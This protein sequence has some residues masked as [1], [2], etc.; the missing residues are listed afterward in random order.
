MVVRNNCFSE[1][2]DYGARYNTTHGAVGSGRG[3]GLSGVGSGPGGHGA[4]NGKIPRPAS[5]PQARTSRHAAN[6]AS[7][8]SMVADSQAI[9]PAPEE[10]RASEVV[11][12]A[13]AGNNAR[14]AEALPAAPKKQA[15]SSEQGARRRAPPQELSI[16]PASPHRDTYHDWGTRLY[17]SNDDT[18]SLSSAQ[19]VI[20][21]IDRG[22]DIPPEHIRPHEFLNY[23][24]FDTAPVHPEDDFSVHASIAPKPDANG[25]YTLGLAVSGRDVTKE[26]RRN[27]GLTMVVD[28]SGSMAEDGRMD[29]LK[30]GLRRMTSELKTGDLVN[31]VLFDH[32]VCTPLENFVV[33]RDSMSV[34]ADTIARIQPNGST[35]LNAGLVR[36]YQLANQSYNEAYTNRVVLI[37]DAIANTGVTDPSLMAT[38]TQNYDQ[39]RIRLSGVG[40]GRDFNDGLLDK[41]TEKGKGA[42]V[43]L[44]SEGEVDAVFGSRFV[45]LIET[46]ANDVHFQLELP[47]SLRMNVFYGEESSVVK[48]DVQAIH[49]FAGTSQLFLSDLMARDGVLTSNERIK[50]NVEYEN[51][52]TG[53]KQTEHFVFPISAIRA[54]SH[55]VSKG[56]LITSFIDGVKDIELSLPR[57]DGV[58][59]ASRQCAAGKQSL[60]E[61][62]QTL[63]TDREVERVL[64]LWE[65]YCK[66]YPQVAYHAAVRPSHDGRYPVR[67]EAPRGKDVW[68]GAQ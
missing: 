19:R 57:Y 30:Q 48:S 64:N 53:A 58:L 6:A 52:E 1:N 3:I 45:S 56:R 60:N 15:A 55:N 27:A 24:S 44:G 39:R 43:F 20:Y 31:I 35:N 34:L 38:V 65:A 7:P 36:G 16:K 9:A 25:V 50:L 2:L 33:G 41:L 5:K 62:A 29:Y 46:I 28:R 42:Y 8:E 18:M 49:Y 54:P 47:P 61:Q 4:P 21:A 22:M 32:Q 37:S 10:K 26:T 59:Y 67:R 17:L 13:G 14:P 68:P 66:R 12:Q 11:T 23:F 51:P 63:R 40:V